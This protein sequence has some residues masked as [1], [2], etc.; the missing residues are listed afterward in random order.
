MAEMRYY[1][2]DML[3]DWLR[4][5]VFVRASALCLLVYRLDCKM[6]VDEKVCT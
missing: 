3:V 5:T 1:T 6:S 4:S 2:V